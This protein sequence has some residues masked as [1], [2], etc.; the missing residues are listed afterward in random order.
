MGG[1][2]LQQSKRERAC[3]TSDSP[4]R[5]QVVSLFLFASFCRNYRVCV[6]S[7]LQH[8]VADAPPRPRHSYACS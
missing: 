7:R 5:C 2:E 8:I 4:G 1:L 3:P 6:R